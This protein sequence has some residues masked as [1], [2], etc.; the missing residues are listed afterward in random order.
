MT[1]Q[2]CTSTPTKLAA[3]GTT[4]G[5]V[6]GVSPSAAAQPLQ[7]PAGDLLGGEREGAVV[8]PVA[9][10]VEVAPPHALV[11]EAELGHHPQAGGVLRADVDL[12]AVQ[13]QLGEAVVAGQR[14]RRRDDAPAGHVPAH[15]VAD[16]GAA[17][18]AEEDRGDGDLPDELALYVDR[19]VQP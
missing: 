17:Q 13:A 15:P 19:E 14:D 4:S 9:V 16:R 18:G 12:Q 7:Q 3:G 8:A 10:D 1:T 6:G 2:P 5:I 11:A